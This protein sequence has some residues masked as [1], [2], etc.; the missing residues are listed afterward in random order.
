M[1]ES[2]NMWFVLLIHAAVWIAP[3]PPL[4]MPDLVLDPPPRVNDPEA[5][6]RGKQLYSDRCMVCHGDGAVGGGVTP[7]LRYM[8]AAKHQ[9]W[10]GVVIG[11]MHQQKG[12]V[13]FA[14]VLTPQDA[15]DIQAFVIERAHQLLE[16]QQTP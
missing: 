13:S 6:A 8:D 15:T 5:I 3:K 4:E 11:G 10:L 9:A 16:S 14:G 12:M 2:D 1:P 7:D